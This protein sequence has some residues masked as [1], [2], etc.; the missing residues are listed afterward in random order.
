MFGSLLRA[1]VGVAL[2]P[3][4]AVVDVVKLPVTALDP[5]KGPFDSTETVAKSVADNVKD[6]LE[7]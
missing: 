2:L 5:H 6:A 3:V 4:A 7:P 1:A